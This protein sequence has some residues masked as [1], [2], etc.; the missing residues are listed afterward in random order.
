MKIEETSPPFVLVVILNWN[1]PGETLAA[2]ASVLQMDYPN[3]R[4]TVVE[5]GST[6]DSAT[7]LGQIEDSRVQLLNS[8][9]NRGY[10]GGCNLGFE[11]ALQSG[12]EYVWLFNNDATTDAATLSSLVRTAQADPSIGLVSP[13][14]ASQQEPSKVL[15]A[16]GFFDPQIPS[17]QSTKILS[18]ARRWASD[19]PNGIM[20]TGTALLVRVAL[21]RKIGMLDPAMFA[22][23]EDTEYSLRS[24]RAGY[25]NVVDFGSVIYHKER[26]AGTRAHEMKSHYWYYMARN[27]VR[28][29]KKHAGFKQRLRPLWWG[30]QEQL[31]NLN[32][33]RGNESSRQAVLAGLWHGW[34]NKGGAYRASFRMPKYLASAIEFHSSR[35]VPDP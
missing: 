30:Y 23:W 7:V 24:T 14:I 21:I 25:R 13:V 1:S 26:C 18:T 15:N 11:L 3:F 31:R 5:N 19:C 9:E 35:W 29:W 34:L 33:L 8:S 17:Y 12:A 4:V 22:Y 32:R 28:F 16:G 20:L 6:D 10:T 2:V 27:E